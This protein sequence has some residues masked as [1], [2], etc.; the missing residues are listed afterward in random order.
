MVGRMEEKLRVAR[1]G[2][3]REW[4]R[5]Y[6]WREWANGAN[7]LFHSFHSLIR[8]IRDFL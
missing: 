5:N 3:W 2:E 1:M 6:E 4:K 7:F 8:A